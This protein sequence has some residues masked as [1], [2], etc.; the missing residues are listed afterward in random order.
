[1]SV[2]V[3]GIVTSVQL[4]K[5]GEWTTLVVGSS[6]RVNDVVKARTLSCPMVAEGDR[7][8]V[9]VVGEVDSLRDGTLQP[10]ITYWARKSVV[11]DASAGGSAEV[12]ALL[13]PDKL[14]KVVA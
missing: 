11:I 14:G 6:G 3:S 10:R 12:H 9:Q 5:D 8:S 1:V 4:S 2:T 13:A 7:I